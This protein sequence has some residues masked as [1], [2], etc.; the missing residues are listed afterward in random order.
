MLRTAHFLELLFE[1]NSPYLISVIDVDFSTLDKLKDNE[2]LRL[3]P[4]GSCGFSLFHWATEPERLSQCNPSVIDELTK[5][6][7][8]MQLKTSNFELQNE[9]FFWGGGTAPS[10]NH[11]PSGE[12]DTP[13]PHPTPLS[14][15]I[16]VPLALVPPPFC[17]QK[18]TG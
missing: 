11:F 14:T 1:S 3:R 10:P 2:L 18:S 15:S 7:L 6:I 9:K 17:F 8:K 4:F 13:S 16:L 5:I 12:G